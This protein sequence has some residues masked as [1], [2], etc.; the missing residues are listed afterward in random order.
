VIGF[1][2]GLAIGFG[3]GTTATGEAVAGLMMGVFF[4]V[5]TIFIL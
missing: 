4:A 5:T 3:A 1:A 2:G